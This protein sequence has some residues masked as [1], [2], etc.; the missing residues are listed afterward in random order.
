VQ[1]ARA[2]PDAV[3]ITIVE[4]RDELGRGLAYSTADPDHRLNAPLDNHLVDPASVEELRQWCARHAIFERDPEALAANGA[5]YLRR[6][7]F[8]AYVGERVREAGAGRRIIHHRA[9]ATGLSVGPDGFAIRTSDGAHLSADLVVIATG[10]DT[11]RLPAPF[12]TLHA[13]PAMLGDPFDA[14]R[15]RALPRATPVLLVGAGLTALDVL[16]TLRRHGHTGGI[17][18]LS[19][20]GVRPRP[21]RTRMGQ[22]NVAALLARIEGEM[23]E[24]AQPLAGP[25]SVLALTRALRR[26]I[27]EAQAKGADW[28]GP[29]DELRDSAWRIWPRLPLAEKRRF[30]RHL[31]TWYDAHRF[32]AP[33]QNDAIALAAETEGKLVFRTGR[34]QEAR[35]AGS[36]AIEVRWTE[37]KG[38]TLEGRFGAVVNC[39]GLDA[40]CGAGTNPFLSGLV[41][42]GLLRPDP[43]GLGFEVD[44]QC[45]PVGRDGTVQPRLRVIGPPSAGSRGDP[46]GV[47][48]IAPQIRRLLPGL[49]AECDSISHG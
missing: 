39:T 19:R 23:P 14:D 38:R 30:L 37:A 22:S 9:L 46:L 2:R 8:G 41:T 17:T 20:R 3:A 33:P 16:S 35:A 12:E 34:V 44:A 45:R 31:R 15:L 29:F 47:I 42:Q 28:H 1:V 25:G 49:L 10:N 5:I 13:H 26:R 43:T 4:P 21:P 36:G 24:Y 27:A 7:D 18:A 48:F 32:R 11:A 40:G 6:S